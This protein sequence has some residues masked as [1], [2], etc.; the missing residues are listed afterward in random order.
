MRSRRISTHRSEL[1][2]SHA[3]EMKHSTTRSEAARWR[4]LSGGKL[5]ESFKRQVPVD[6]RFVVDFLA[7]R[8][9]LVV[10]VDGAYHKR[11]AAADARRDRALERLG[12]RV[13]RLS[14]ELV[15]RQ[16]PEAIRLIREALDQAR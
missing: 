14:D 6:G 4:W 9:R 8:W 15:L 16:L 12:Y 5:G 3:R 2:A 11:R 7:A 13:L 1:L 10:E